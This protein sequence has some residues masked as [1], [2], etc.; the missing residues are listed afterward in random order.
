MSDHMPLVSICIPHWQMKTLATVCLRSIRKYSSDVDYEVIVIDN[1]SKDNSLDYLRSLSWI[2]L[3]ERSS[4]TT[5]SD[6]TEAYQTALDIALKEVRGQYFLST[7][8]DVVVKREGW[9][10][11]LI[12]PLEDN[13]RCAAVGAE[14]LKLHS[15][16][17]NWCRGAFDTK[18]LKLWLRRNIMADAGATFCPG[19]KYPRDFC[20]MYRTAQLREHEI[21]FISPTKLSSGETVYNQ[22]RDLNYEMQ[23]V[24]V[25]EMREWINHI[26]HGTPASHPGPRGISR[27]RTQL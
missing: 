23:L 22:L 10:R 6:P 18:R 17:H 21:T 9:L 14:K 7:H 15:P 4:S 19:A 11:R 24:S 16:L 5:P 27:R 8:T 13:P 20:S 12:Q 2:R 3:I 1:G 26:E 25:P